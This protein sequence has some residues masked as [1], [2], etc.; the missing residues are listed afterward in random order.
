MAD[1]DGRDDR[2]GIGDALMPLDDALADLTGRVN[3]AVGVERVPLRRAAG[4]VLAADVASPIDVP[5]H[6]NSAVD[7]YAVRHAD[8]PPEGEA[9]LRIAG[10]AAAGHPFAGTVGPGEAV[11][12]FTGAPMPAGPDTVLMQE[13]CREEDGAVIFAGRIKAGAN[14]R[15]AGEDVAA[16]RRVLA[17]GRRLRPQEVALAAAVGVT[18]LEVYRPLRVAVFSTGDE[19]RDPG[20]DL[21]EGG[22]YDSNRYAIMALAEGLGGAVTDLGILPDRLDAVR[23]A[24]GAAAA[25]HDLILTSGGVSLGEEDHV[26]AAV[27]AQ[28]ALH[29]WR[30]A[31]KPGRPVALGQV[32]D[33]PFVGLPGN[34]VATMVTFA[35]VARPL[36]LG[37]MG[38]SAE[39]PPRYRVPAAFSFRKKPGRREF[40][41]GR[42]VHRDGR[43]AVEVFAAQGSGILSSMTESDGLIDLPE[44]LEQVTPGQPLDFLPF[45]EVFG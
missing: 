15:F 27:Q 25:D 38:A 4:R 40:Q 21:P 36:M 34:P 8:L 45:R 5:R 28:G 11:R 43:L 12:I 14:R 10:R 32:G 22:I 33:V 16:G 17:A 2:F 44:D 35:L 37:L 13:D 7:G 42:L 20:Q 23:D 9:R 26:K 18:E 29:F 41:R 39:A 6:D 19:V 31:I 1:D 24:L 3:A 30:L